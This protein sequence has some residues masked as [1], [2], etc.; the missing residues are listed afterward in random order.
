MPIRSYHA[1]WRR[2]SFRSQL[3]LWFGSLCLLALLGVGAY[4]G[5]IA[6]QVLTNSGG[7][8]LYVSA[9]SAADLLNSKLRER[10]QEIDL[11][12][13]SPLMV[14]GA[15]D[16]DELRR[17][18]ELRKTTHG[19][20]AWIG[21]A[22]VDGTVT[23]AIG[24]LLVGEKVD[25][26]PWFKA[27][28]SGIFVGDVHEAVLLAKRLPN[29][30]PDQPLRFIDF[31][32]PIVGDD[33]R[34]RGVLGSHAHWSWVTETV[35][36]VVLNQASHRRTEV[37]IA[38]Q[39]GTVLYPF[40]HAGQL[41]L[42]Q[43]L[44]PGAHYETLDWAD[45]G[46]FLTSMATVRLPVEDSPE[47]QIA[48]RQPIDVAREE[49][50]ALRQ[51]LLLLGVLVAAICAFVAH[52]LASRVSRPVEQLAHAARQ[53]ERREDN[54]SYPRE[55][56]S[57]EIDQLNQSFQSMTHSLLAREG[58]LSHLNKSLETQVSER[59]EALR[60]AN[61]ELERLVIRDALT[62]LYNRRRFDEKL[63]EDFQLFQ[64]G[65]RAFALLVI[66]VD[67]FKNVNDTHGH[68]AGDAVLQHL[69]AVIA[70][71]VRATDFVARY[72]GEEFV[73]LLPAPQQDSEALI[74]AE[75]LREAVATATFPA[76]GRVTISLG[77]S[78]AAPDDTEGADVLRRADQGLYLAKQ[79]GRNR[80]VSVPVGT[81]DAAGG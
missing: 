59:T 8:A 17:A 68:P 52:R 76:V 63:R 47:W 54:P 80:T 79:Q 11:F 13:H 66:D 2:Q 51:R 14:R 40:R 32:A 27:A 78:R 37:L 15:L 75:K 42:P 25:K 41:S 6:T 3:T 28:L 21:V 4:V 5:R 73:V 30:Q 29:A 70:D 60:M 61:T 33:G 45:G 34:V 48:L 58:D 55:G 81:E 16:S 56:H 77:L 72:G 36:A 57:A 50:Q 38:D 9:R 43:R 18:L 64:R 49:V 65:G 71:S 46:S 62:G 26:R 12:R 7:E 74:V 53:I 1:L 19:E 35:E 69:A 31:A 39:A 20:Y 10:S 44:Q 67:H 22:D 24:G 23:Q